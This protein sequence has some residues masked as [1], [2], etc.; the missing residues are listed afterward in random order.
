MERVERRGSHHYRTI[1]GSI[2]AILLSSLEPLLLSLPPTHQVQLS[3]AERGL[4][5]GRREERWRGQARDR[6]RRFE[7]SYLGFL[8]SPRR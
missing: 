1:G 8:Q 7:G 2:Q 5:G 6:R 3:Q 4:R